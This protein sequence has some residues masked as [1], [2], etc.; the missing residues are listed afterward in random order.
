MLVCFILSSAAPLV[1]GR[2]RGQG[3]KE[4]ETTQ[5]NIL[6]HFTESRDLNKTD[7]GLCLQ[8]LTVHLNQI[9]EREVSCA[10]FYTKIFNN[11]LSYSKSY[12]AAYYSN[13]LIDSHKQR[14]CFIFRMFYIHKV[15]FFLFFNRKDPWLER[16][17]KGT[18]FHVQTMKAAE[19]CCF[20]EML[21]GRVRLINT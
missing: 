8:C 14:K 3:K 5:R 17:N 7:A 1:V 12:F 16:V 19:K 9:E 10:S 2:G 18:L 13:I 15:F 11:S 4:T 21:W 6:P 20:F